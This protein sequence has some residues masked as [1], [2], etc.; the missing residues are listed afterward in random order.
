MDMKSRIGILVLLSSLAAVIITTNFSN[1][2]VGTEDLEE[3]SKDE[4]TKKRADWWKKKLADPATGEIPEHIFAKERIFAQ[5]L[6]HDGDLASR[7]QDSLV[8][9]VRGP[10][11]ASG[12]VRGLDVDIS[13]NSNVIAAGVSGGIYRSTNAG[14]TWSK[15]TK[16]EDMHNVTCITQDKRSGKTNIWYAGTGEGSGYSGSTHSNGNGI[17]K[18]TDNGLSWSV[19]DSTVSNSPSQRTAWNICW[20]IAIDRSNTTQ[21]EVYAAVNGG[22]MKSVDG[23]LNWT[24]TLGNGD[25]RT[26]YTWVRVSSTGVVYAAIGKTGVVQPGIWRSTD[27]DTWTNITPSTMPSNFLRIVFDIAPSNENV[28]YFLANTP[29]SG[30]LAGNTSSR[31]NEG[32]SLFKYTY[33]SG[34]GSGN[35]GQWINRSSNI[36]KNDND[37][38]RTFDTQ[39]GYDMVCRISPKNE[40][41][42]FIGGTNLFRSSNGF[43]N[44][45]TTIQCGGY[46]IEPGHAFD[47]YRYPN[48]HPD[49]HD[50]VFPSN[51]G[52]D[53]YSLT[54]GGVSYS[55]NIEASKV[56][57]EWR[58]YG[59]VS[60]QFY[61]VAIDHQTVNGVLVGG[62]QDN[63]TQYTYSILP[64]VDFEDPAKGDGSYCAVQKGTSPQGAGIYYFSS[65][66]GVTYKTEMGNNG[67]RLS[68]QQMNPI[69]NSSN[70]SFINPFTLDYTD[71][72]IM[73]MNYQDGNTTRLKR[74]TT[75]GSIPLF[76]ERNPNNAGWANM[77]VN[78]GGVISALKTSRYNPGY[79]L[80]VG[81]ENGKVYRIDNAHSSNP[82]LTDISFNSPYLVGQYVADIAVHP[83]DANKVMVVFSNYNVY[84]VYYTEDGGSTWDGIAGNLEEA[85]RPGMPINALG[86]GNGPSVNTCAFVESLDGTS[87]FVGTS[88]GLYGTNKIDGHN[89]VWVQQ[90]RYAIGNVIVHKLDVRDT[91]D[92]L[93][94][95][96]YGAG[97]YGCNVTSAEAVISI[98]NVESTI[99]T[100]KIYPNP[101]SSRATL[102]YDVEFEGEYTIEVY[103]QLGRFEKE[104]YRNNLNPGLAE[105]EIPLEG[106]SNG[107]HY[108]KIRSNRVN[109]AVQFI[110]Q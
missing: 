37:A 96:T 105:I 84:S 74:N 20:N 91:D 110:I 1:N 83:S 22:I 93:A 82:T 5:T 60:T 10:F 39:G 16:Q 52:S 66:N 99:N 61:T 9:E 24:Q 90:G 64:N 65:Q 85:L 72:N 107:V 108:C 6:P 89:T 71:N 38:G 49:Q 62:T 29:G 58:N 106:L 3:I 14:I 75:L 103:D 98:E 18:S 17:Y 102:S 95:A 63:G 81:T 2:Q 80:Y 87:Y 4:M 44:T 54:D 78:I 13:N 48:Q 56:V 15:V 7:G 32:N 23:G 35:G 97:L 73:Y 88:T 28:L 101:A 76:N 109:K 69:G 92:Y 30:Q 11:N 36:P 86:F 27:G 42:V 41:L 21:D 43:S 79:R 25:S 50:I 19:L 46:N 104:V 47:E 26:N 40:N 67:Q 34:N 68:F 57:Y 77:P 31:S 100:T 33:L 51:T 12:R 94:I 59:L 8:Y 70:F 53:A 55:G 45:T